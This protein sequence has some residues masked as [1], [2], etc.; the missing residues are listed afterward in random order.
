MQTK[1]DN[2]KNKVAQGLLVIL[3]FTSITIIMLYP[4]TI[5]LFEGHF[6]YPQSDSVN[7]LW[8]L[9][10][11]NYSVFNLHSNPYEMSYLFYPN[12]VAVPLIGIPIFAGIL[13][14]P[15][16]NFFGLLFSYNFLIFSSFV[17]GGYGAFLLCNYFTKNKYASIVGG[18]IFA[19][20]PY[21]M[22]QAIGHLNL[23]SIQGI[24]FFILFL[25]HMKDKQK[26]YSFLYGGISLAFATFFGDLHYL[27]FLTIFLIIFLVYHLYSNKEKILNKTFFI[28]LTA[29][30]GVFILLASP[31]FIILLENTTT[32]FNDP[33]L[34][35]SVHSV[36]IANFVIPPTNSTVFDTF[37]NDIRKDWIFPFNN[38]D[39]S[40]IGYSVLAILIFSF[41]KF[42]QENRFWYI[43][44]LIFGL[45]SLGTSL[46]IYGQVITL[47]DNFM[48]F[49]LIYQIPFLPEFRTP[50]R[51]HVMTVLALAVISSITI[52]NIFRKIKQSRLTIG[53]FLI[54]IIVILIEYSTLPFPFTESKNPE[55]YET[56]S[57]EQDNFAVL[58]I[59]LLKTYNEV[60]YYG[61]IHQKPLTGG[62]FHRMPIGIWT[63]YTNI[64]II[65]ST[66][67][68]TQPKFLSYSNENT[69]SKNYDKANVC[70]FEH[71]NIKYVIL[72]KQL[73]T[74]EDHLQLKNYLTKLLGNS[75]FEDNEITVFTFEEKIS[76]CK[77]SYF[78]YLIAT[79]AQSIIKDETP[80]WNSDEWFLVLHSNTNQSIEIPLNI[81][82]LEKPGRIQVFQS[83]ILIN[84][85]E[86]IQNDE[87]Q[88]KSLKLQISDGKNE[89]QLQA[90]SKMLILPNIDYEKLQNQS[91]HE[92]LIIEYQINTLYEK[93][94]NRNADF[95]GLEY[96]TNLVVN[97]GK[98]LDFIENELKKSL[99]T[100]DD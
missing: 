92:K 82:N 90:T 62:F 81:V 19:F 33:I 87:V 35:A 91:F 57:G 5:H 75:S 98:D 8:G 13:S 38:E 89:F 52:N 46:K 66:Y 27:L 97:D 59:G 23:A 68:Q 64:P 84:E 44:A 41:I 80:Y 24:P 76:S 51:L 14:S 93:I 30:F 42:R 54:V 86:I 26:K 9:W 65:H 29:C 53:V 69:L 58:D 1:T 16:Q 25:F 15:I 12:L 60:L 37:G 2:I 11:S 73:L 78:G 72:H 20:A 95:S 48:P 67:F 6:G 10:W 32:K 96:F 83:D 31:F 94:L 70:A 56:I 49:E 39:A 36:D 100:K 85:I 40:F 63:D 79:Q 17:F 7:N 88:I 47:F 50:A 71:L 99:L 4:G 74:A 21:H 61:T 45:L 18:I 22:F 3:L 55:F 77:E 34:G 43:V 28:K